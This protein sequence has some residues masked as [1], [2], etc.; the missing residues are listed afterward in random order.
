MKKFFSEFKEFI[1]RGNVVDLAV[2]VIV[3]G[4]FQAIVNSLINDL[5]MPFIGLI[6]GG[7]NFADQ[8]IVLKV[9][10]GVELAT[11]EAAKTAADATALGAT[12]WAYGAFITAVINFI[13][14]AFVIFVLVKL[15]N[16]A[17]SIGKKEEETVEEVTT[18][19]CPF[20]YS[21]IDI[22]ATRCPHCTSQ[23]E[24]SAE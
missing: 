3:G 22:K 16:K 4:A 7:I 14:M 8:F 5:V 21:E 19:P 20:C 12:V 23:L 24:K 13:V 15:I 17:Q 2:A 10:E 6:T 11:V 18:K 1:M 9:P